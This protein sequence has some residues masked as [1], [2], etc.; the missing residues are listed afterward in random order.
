MQDLTLP[1]AL[2]LA[3]QSSRRKR[4]PAVSLGVWSSRA[5]THRPRRANVSKPVSLRLYGVGEIPAKYGSRVLGCMSSA[6]DGLWVF[7]L[8]RKANSNIIRAAVPHL[9]EAWSDARP[10]FAFPELRSALELRA[11]VLQSPGFWEFV[12]ALN[13]LET[14]RKYLTDRHE[15]LKD[16]NY[17]NGLDAERLLYENSL[18]KIKQVSETIDVLRKAHVSEVDIAAI[19]RDLLFV[20]TLQ[21]QSLQDKSVISYA[22]L[23]DSRV[24]AEEEIVDP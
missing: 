2:P 3:V 10:E 9:R 19:V 5:S 21:L 22:D 7:E 8:L 14:L 23:T 18:L 16:V 17:R 15:R 20:P 24:P 6:Y 12:G 1:L 11:V 13:P 4:P